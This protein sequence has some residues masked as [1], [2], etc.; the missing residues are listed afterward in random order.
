ML[1]AALGVTFALSLPLAAAEAGDPLEVKAKVLT[2]RAAP[3]RKADP[4]AW[5]KRGQRLTEVARDG[6]WI[7]VNTGLPGAKASGWVH[8]RHVAPADPDDGSAAESP[9]EA[10]APAVAAVEAPPKPEPA[11]P[12][13]VPSEAASSEVAA[14]QTPATDANTTAG[15]DVVATA[16][17]EQPPQNASIGAKS[18]RAAFEAFY[19]EYRKLTA[20]Y[21]ALSDGKDLFLS[22]VDKGDGKLEL[23][24][25]DYWFTGTDKDRENDVATVMRLWREVQDT[26]AMIIVVDEGG[27]EQMRMFEQ[28]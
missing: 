19:G 27:Q 15:T 18:S 10:A 14:P 17:P 21:R 7:Q 22:A 28:L 2:M 8:G 25:T 5:L 12:E 11:P 26:K 1:A 9:A 13:A 23:T 16:A 24:A 6:L 3:N 4:R 20:R